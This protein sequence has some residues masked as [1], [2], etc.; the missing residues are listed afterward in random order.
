MKVYIMQDGKHVEIKRRTELKV[1]LSKSQKRE[2][3]EMRKR[4]SGSLEI[5]IVDPLHDFKEKVKAQ[6]RGNA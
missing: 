4:R 2:L 3:R 1:K 6:A 5:E